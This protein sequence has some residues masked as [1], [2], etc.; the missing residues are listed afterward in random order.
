M[1]NVKPNEGDIEKRRR[2]E[3]PPK[4]GEDGEFIPASS[5]KF[6]KKQRQKERKEK[7]KELEKEKPGKEK[8]EKEKT[9]KEKIEEEVDPKVAIKDVKKSAT[10]TSSRSKS[11]ASQKHNKF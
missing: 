3:T 6:L 7:E 1:E 4:E 8:P 2:V 9:E 5:K 10:K 11:K